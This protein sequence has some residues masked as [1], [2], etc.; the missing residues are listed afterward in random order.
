MRDLETPHH[1]FLSPSI[2]TYS[3]AQRIHTKFHLKKYYGRSF[4]YRMSLESPKGA[5]CL[6]S[7]RYHDAFIENAY[8]H[9]PLLIMTQFA[10]NI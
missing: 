9:Q 2:L 4:P 5:H 6:N 3:N 8:C 10:G 7:I 1:S